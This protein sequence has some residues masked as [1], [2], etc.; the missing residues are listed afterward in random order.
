MPG[1]KFSRVA[2]GAHTAGTTDIVP[3]QISRH[4]PDHSEVNA[5]HHQRCAQNARISRL[6][7]RSQKL[8]LESSRTGCAPGL[9]SSSGM[10]PPAQDRLHSSSLR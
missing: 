9:S 3:V 2:S 8:S 7:C 1:S 4:D 6:K 5:V 10:E